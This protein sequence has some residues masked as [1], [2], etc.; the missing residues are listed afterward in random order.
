MGPTEASKQIWKRLS[1]CGDMTS[2]RS[3]MLDGTDKSTGV[4]KH[5]ISGSRKAIDLIFRTQVGSSGANNGTK[6]EGNRT[7]GC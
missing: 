2:C 4:R 7:R 1:G 3:G 5:D 6:F